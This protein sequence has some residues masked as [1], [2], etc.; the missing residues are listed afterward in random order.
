MRIVQISD[1]HLINPDQSNEISSSR[2]KN[3]Q[4]C[5]E[6]VN[7]LVETPDQVIHTGD[8]T[9]HGLKKEYHLFLDLLESLSLPFYPTPGNKDRKLAMMAAFK[10]HGI[11][12]LH[13]DFILYEV[14]DYPVRL[15]SVDTASEKSNKGDFDKES[16]GALSTLLNRSPEKP[17]ALFMHHPPFDVSNSCKPLYEFTKP[18]KIHK[19][20]EILNLQRQVINLFCGHIHRYRESFVREIKATTVPSLATDLNMEEDPDYDTNLPMYLIHQY[21]DGL[22]FMTKKKLVDA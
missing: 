6:D 10:T 21:I 19:F 4:R 15:I 18:N 14:N 5:I 20:M 7:Q 1:S 12:S 9:H 16:L 3:L 13:E 2:A 8:I 17:T 11:K 22:G